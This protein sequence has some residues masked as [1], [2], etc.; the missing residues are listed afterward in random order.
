MDSAIPLLLYFPYLLLLGWL[1]YSVF[2]L[3]KANKEPSHVNTF[4]L[5]AI[6]GL[7]TTIG[8]FGTF[9]GIAIGLYDFQVDDIQGS[10]TELLGGMKL[11]FLTS[12]IGIFLSM[13]SGMFMR[14]ILHKHGDKLRLPISE[15]S[16][17]L[18][19]LQKEAQKRQ[20][21][22]EAIGEDTTHLGSIYEEVKKQPPL[23]SSIL[24]NL[25]KNRK[26]MEETN[27]DSTKKLLEEIKAT[28]KHLIT[29]S[30][31]S[32][33]NTQNMV[34]TLNE[35]HRLMRDKFTEFS[36]L[37]AQANTE[38]LRDAMENL[39]ADF[40]EM[41]S[42]LITSLVNQNFQEL[43]QSVQ[44]LN[45]WQKENREQVDSLY[46][47]LTLLLNRTDEFTVAIEEKVPL[48]VAQLEQTAGSIERMSEHVAAISS[49]E[50]ELQEILN[51]LKSVMIEDERFVEMSDRVN[52]SIE[53]L[54]Q[55]ST[56]LSSTSQDLNTTTS[57]LQEIYSWHDQNKEVVG[58]LVEQ[59]ETTSENF[60]G[61]E[62]VL[63]KM[64]GH[65]NAISGSEGELQLILNALKKVM[66]EDE[67]FVHMGDMVTSSV[68]R[69][70]ATAKELAGTENALADTTEALNDIN[71]WHQENRGAI[72]TLVTQLNEA[73]GSLTQTDA[74]LSNT[75]QLVK[76]LVDSESQ[77]ANILAELENVALG[78]GQFRE[79]M[80]KI[81]ATAALME[82]TSKNAEE[83]QA[84]ITEWLNREKGLHSSMLLF[85]RA[86]ADLSKHLENLEG[87]RM[88]E[89]QVLD[90][91]FDKRIQTALDKSF[92]NLDELVMEYVRF[93]EKNRKIEIAVRNNN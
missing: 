93:M 23:L 68:N 12:I 77:L 69:L 48:A 10:I 11:A 32:N 83:E 78:D 25:S 67:R 30:E 31:Q 19:L 60:K 90:N 73:S 39:I 55:S 65:L 18:E 42:D 28:N 56:V 44:S 16:R 9:F 26:T 70:S 76:Q 2:Y 3:I 61:N 24:D 13:V 21:S 43:N 50:G 63:K 8:V 33:E 37:M 71:T 81:K 47:K 1:A 84:K 17:R 75:S 34:E 88:E 6:P 54:Q 20:L 72:E 15:E 14:S 59:M 7:F 58:T 64:A 41:F 4:L 29:A 80:N 46:K 86:I 45:G 79:L 74:T 53:K 85:N 91:S 5:Q 62:E 35:N 52:E 36:Q 22:L 27:A 57:A 89:W 66:I 40:N 87:I 38:A 92:K 49:S 51:I 82:S